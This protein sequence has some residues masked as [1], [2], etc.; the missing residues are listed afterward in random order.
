M[1]TF[2]PPH[3][4]LCTNHSLECQPHPLSLQTQPPS[5][6]LVSSGTHSLLP[7]QTML[8]FSRHLITDCHTV[9]HNC[10]P[11]LPCQTICSQVQRPCLFFPILSEPSPGLG[12]QGPG[13]KVFSKP[14]WLQA[15]PSLAPT[16]W[17]HFSCSCL[18]RKLNWPNQTFV[19]PLSTG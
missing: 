15:E 3:L 7:S 18:I 6:G 17:D 1:L 13:Q 10:R 14:I 11:C 4:C 2:Q 5:R 8:F 12:G 9:S 19:F 16:T